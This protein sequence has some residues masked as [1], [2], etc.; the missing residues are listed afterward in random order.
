MINILDY[1]PVNK[2]NVQKI[3]KI[4]LDITKKNQNLGGFILIPEKNNRGDYGY[5]HLYYYKGQ[6][7]LIVSLD[8]ARIDTR[9]YIS[10]NTD[11]ILDQIKKD[12]KGAK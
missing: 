3:L 8:G 11:N 12:A 7:F 2:K 9:Y 5:D 10:Y 4:L 6:L 1:K